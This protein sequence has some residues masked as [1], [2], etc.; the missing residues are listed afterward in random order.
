MSNPGVIILDGL[1]SSKGKFKRFQ[2]ED[3]I[4]E[5]IHLHIDNMRVDFTINEFLAFSKMIKKSLIELDFLN[6]NKFSTFDI[7]FLKECSDI[8]PN[9]VDIKAEEVK[10]SE[11]KCIVHSNYGSD[12]NFIKIVSIEDS[13]AYQYLEGSKRKFI[14]YS[15]YNYF[16]ADNEKRL[17]ENLTSIKKNGYP[18]NDKYVVLF[19][20]QNYIR[21]GQHRAAILAHMYNLNTN[22]KIKRFYFSG[23][24][25]Y[26]NHRKNNTKT[27]IKWLV[28]KVCGPLLYLKNRK[29]FDARV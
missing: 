8:L 23:K 13:P 16:N 6:G 25:H 14:N 7:H 11:L 10:L 3:N 24:S 20:G 26:F 4:G 17:L 27:F 22:I 29:A 19:N 21:D 2:I 28:K 12:L 1:N 18:Y 15:Q 9:L 5:A